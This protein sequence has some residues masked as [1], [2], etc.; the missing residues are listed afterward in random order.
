VLPFTPQAYESGRPGSNGPRRS[1]APVLCRLSYVRRR[2]ARLD[3]NQR[4]LPSQSS[5]LSTELRAFG[6]PPAGIE[7]APRPYKG[8]VLAVDTTEAKMETAGV[9][10]TSCS[11]QARGA[12]TARPRW[13]VSSADGWSRTTTARGLG[14]TARRARQCSA[15]AC[16]SRVAGRVRTGAG[17]AHNPGCFRLHHGHHEERGRPGSNRRPLA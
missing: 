14:V 7:P 2:Y 1:G 11:L 8:R 15:S 6:E 5:A 17:G 4:V 13:V 16:T 3:S 9:E 10:P 12:A